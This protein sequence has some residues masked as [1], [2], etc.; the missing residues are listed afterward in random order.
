ML[1]HL[2]RALVVSVLFF[3]LLGLAYPALITGVGQAFFSHQANG[4][5]NAYGSSAIGQ[6]WRAPHWFVGRPSAS[7]YDPMASGAANLGP[8]SKVLVTDV[9]AQIAAL[10]REGIR[11]TNDL[12]TSS[13]S[14]LDPDISPAD[15][16]AQ[17]HA[18]ARADH[19][20][21]AAV[22]RLIAQHTSGAQWGFLGAPTV[23]V[24]QLNIALAHLRG[25]TR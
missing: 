16:L 7:N 9:T 2:R 11:P 5:L 6:S 3:V 20:P 12:V 24:L 1:T 8:R 23:D 4:S 21:V 25:I 14:G 22:R 17:A 18:V 13:G 15:A 10:K 19:L